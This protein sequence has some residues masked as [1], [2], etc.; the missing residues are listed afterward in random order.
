MA[1]W[2]EGINWGRPLNWS[3]ALAP[4]KAPGASQSQG[5]TE[6]NQLV[7]I[8][9]Q[10]Q[11]ENDAAR[12][13]RQGVYGVPPA[14][15]YD[16]SDAEVWKRL[17]AAQ[18]PLQT[19]QSNQPSSAQ[20][21]AFRTPVYQPA[22][23]DP[24]MPV[25]NPPN[26]DPNMPSFNTRATAYSPQRG[27]SAMEGGYRS[28]RPGHDGNKMVSTVEDYRPD[29]PNS[30]ISL[31]GDP[32]Q[33]GKR[34]IIPQLSWITRDGKPVTYNNVR[35][36]V[37]DTGGAFKGAGTS[38]FDIPVGRDWNNAQMNRQPFLN[39]RLQFIDASGNTGSTPPMRLGVPPQTSSAGPYQSVVPQDLSGANGYTKDRGML[40]QGNGGGWRDAPPMTGQQTFMPS[41]GAG[42]RDTPPLQ[43]AKLQTPE[44]YAQNF[45]Q[46]PGQSVTGKMPAPNAFS[47]GAGWQT[48]GS[49][50]WPDGTQQWMG[51]GR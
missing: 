28:A 38:H 35:A 27:G 49:I 21:N 14:K 31:A 11:A 50:M 15:T 29:D 47:S 7:E 18:H 8:I 25:V 39:G 12:A 33:Y 30:Y 26:V 34:Y 36:E 44:M 4:I 42:W 22:N 3:T 2:S 37:M 24:N 45:G 32:S 6:P 41:D 1:D 23:T 17:F 5:Q 51:L 20:A 48:D 19:D 10:L 43:T 9:K 40:M 16:D 46:V 13:P